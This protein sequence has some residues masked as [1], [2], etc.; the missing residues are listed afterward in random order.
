MSTPAAE[1]LALVTGVA[2]LAA[3]ECTG[4]IRRLEQSDDLIGLRNA[5]PNLVASILDLCGVS[6]SLATALENLELLLP[7]K[8]HLRRQWVSDYYYLRVCARALDEI[9]HGARV[10]PGFEADSHDDGRESG[11]VNGNSPAVE[12][13]TPKRVQRFLLDLARLKG[14]LR[15]GLSA[16]DLYSLHC[17]ISQ[18]ESVVDTSQNGSFSPAHP[19][20]TSDATSLTDFTHPSVPSLTCTK[21]DLEILSHPSE[22]RP[23]FASHADESMKVRARNK[24]NPAYPRA[25]TSWVTPLVNKEWN[26]LRESVV[27][28]FGLDRKPEEPGR[29][30][31]T[32]WVL[33]YTRQTWPKQAGNRGGSPSLYEMAVFEAQHPELPAL[34]IAAAFGLSELCREFP[35]EPESLT[36]DAW[37]VVLLSALLGPSA[38]L[39][40]SNDSTWE[41]INEPP[42]SIDQRETIRV[43]LSRGFGASD[44][45]FTLKD[46]QPVPAD[47]LAFIVSLRL[48]DPD[49]FFEV[50]RLFN[51]HSSQLKDLLRPGPF[52][53]VASSQYEPCASDESRDYLSTVLSRLIET[54]FPAGEVMHPLS[55]LFGGVVQ[56][57]FEYPLPFTSP[58]KKWY[59]PSIPD[60]RFAEDVRGVIRDEN[61]LAVACL[62]LDPRWDPNLPY[63]EGGSGHGSE[64]GTILHMAAEFSDSENFEVLELVVQ[65]GAD[66]ER[67]DENNRTAIMLCEAPEPYRFLREKGAD[68]MHVDVDG[69]TTWHFA[70]ANVDVSCMVWLLREDPTL[71]QNLATVNGSGLTPLTE[72]IF[73]EGSDTTA[74]INSILFLCSAADG[75]DGCLHSPYPVL[76]AAAKWGS[77]DVIAELIDLG[78]DTSVL[79]C[80]GGS[81]LHDINFMAS[82]GMVNLL[83]QVC[84]DLPVMRSAD[85]HTPIE[86]LFLNYDPANARLKTPQSSLVL[87]S[88]VVTALLTPEII[89]SRDDRGRGLWERF[90][91]DV[92]EYWGKGLKQGNYHAFSVLRVALQQIARTRALRQYEEETNTSGISL[93]YRAAKR[94]TEG[95]PTDIIISVYKTL[96]AETTCLERFVSGA[97]VL[98]LAATG[99]AANASPFL[100]LLLKNGVSVHQRPPPSNGG[101]ARRSFLEMACAPGNRVTA[102]TFEKLL[103]YADPE[104]LDDIDETNQG[105]IHYL[106]VPG[107]GRDQKLTA[108]LDAGANPNLMRWGRSPALVS[109]ILDRQHDAATILL[110]KKADPALATKDG[111][112]A[113]LAAASR[114]SIRMLEKLKSMVPPGFNWQRTCKSHFTIIHPGGGQI[115]TTASNCN[116]LHLAAFNGLD[117]IV[118]FYCANFDI[119]VNH[120]IVDNLHRPLHL[121]AVGGSGPCIRILHEYGA[122]LTAK[123]DEGFTAL[124][125]AVKNSQMQAV[126]TLLEIGGPGLNAIVDHESLTPFMHAL[127]IGFPNIIKLFTD[128]GAFKVEGSANTARSRFIGQAIS[129]AIRTG[130]LAQCKNLLSVTSLEDFETCPLRCDGCSPVMQAVREGKLA[131]LRWLLDVGCTGF[132]GTCLTHVRRKKDSEDEPP[133]GYNALVSVCG[134]P[135]MNEGLPPLLSAYLKHGI[136]WTTAPVSPIHFAVWADNLA[137]VKAIMKHIRAN[138]TH[139]RYVGG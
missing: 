127:R 11:A 123:A 79:D 42:Y 62:T 64:G 25:A 63:R 76:H 124:H 92:V 12:R 130:D 134:N 97:E 82:P 30:N 107:P 118:K 35:H 5:L 113:A 112:D 50:L 40:S 59:Q 31:L 46:P 13:L 104:R 125:T 1:Q 80:N 88:D 135:A 98:D 126:K 122:D 19:S 115:T 60:S 120:A 57:A 137:A 129:K 56:L 105:L 121:A 86:T 27:R 78:A 100:D 119:D 101:T 77:E 48:R 37:C 17:A 70:A 85:Q 133:P 72:A 28:L 69:R 29:A 3:R 43:V 44:S 24:T 68:T 61:A 23:P 136:D 116:A 96:F 67:T 90:C 15:S 58:D 8:Q 32:Q 106:I 54:I 51:R 22:N 71:Q 52:W 65:S 99:V 91:C 139:Y 33:E 102:S 4:L 84:A 39:S 74:A 138:A 95:W 87:S 49:L 47:Y 45:L 66:L 94:M 131:V 73:Y 132:V 9:R 21:R 38:L 55:T 41:R 2:S 53:A 117:I 109:Y 108:L 103:E 111:M 93:F 128:V 81:P 114:G 75:N 110:E 20:H 83:F 7:A 16:L 26:A 89:D 10:V 36:S 18:I 34:V 6:H 14:R